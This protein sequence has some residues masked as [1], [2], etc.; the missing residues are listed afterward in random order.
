MV[1]VLIEN[2]V[3]RDA[4]VITYKNDDCLYLTDADRGP[5]DTTENSSRKL[6]FP[7]NTGHYFIRVTA[8]DH[9]SGATYTLKVLTP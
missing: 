7:A 5:Y 3:S 2:L 1:T 6:E 8:D 9:S 4:Q